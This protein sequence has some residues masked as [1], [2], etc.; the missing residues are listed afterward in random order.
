[1]P[2]GKWLT[3]ISLCLVVA[4]AAPAYTQTR[5]KKPTS[6]ATSWKLIAVKITGSQRYTPEEI[7]SASGLQIGQTVSE[8]DFKK[9]TERLGQTG[10]FGGTAY[11]FDYSPDGAKLELQVSDS[12]QFVPVHFENFVWFSEQELTDKLRERVPLLKNRE[13][14]VGGDLADQVSDAL[15]AMLIERKVEGKADYL[16]EAQGDGPIQSFIFSVTGHKVQIRNLEF[17]DAQEPQLALLQAAGKKL[18]GQEYKLDV[19]QNEAKLEFIPVYLQRGY[20]KATFGPYQAKIMQD[21]KDETLVDVVVPVTPGSQYKLNE[22]R[23]SGDTTFPPAQLR[24]LIHVKM[25]EP[26]DAVQLDDDLKE[27]GKLYATKGYMAPTFQAEPEVDDSAL[28]VAYNIKITEG[29]VYKMGELEIRGLDSRTKDH[30]LLYWKLLEGDIY[31]SSYV[32][33]FIAES[34]KELPKENKWN[35]NPHEAVNDDGTVDVSLTYE[36]K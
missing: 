11:A 3:T 24:P 9:A 35:I 30:L 4:L 5:P 8:D 13:L 31:D 27:I 2:S 22:V 25:G 19:I 33:R 18:Q 23:L 32:R 15:Q 29:P 6:S 1:M 28:T 21:G 14:P 26:V 36:T 10:A 34:S 20:L 16:R 7:V 12:P 17:T